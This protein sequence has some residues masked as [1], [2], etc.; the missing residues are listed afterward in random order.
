VLDVADLHRDELT[1]PAAFRAVPPRVAQSM[2]ILIN[3]DGHRLLTLPPLASALARCARRVFSARF[4][5][6]R[7]TGQGCAFWPKTRVEVKRPS[8]ALA[9]TILAAGSSLPGRTRDARPCRSAGIPHFAGIAGRAPAGPTG[10]GPVAFALGGQR[11]GPTAACASASRGN[12]VLFCGLG[13]H[14]DLRGLPGGAKGIRTSDLCGACG[15]ARRP[16]RFRF[17]KA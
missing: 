13:N 3:M 7:M 15:F 16:R 17:W 14:V 4:G 6:C 12:V 9:T 2:T 10:F 11:P 1:I 5:P 8:A